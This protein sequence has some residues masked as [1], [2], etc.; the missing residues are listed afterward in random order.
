MQDFAEAK[1]IC[2][3]N[4]HTKSLI[5]PI[6]LTNERVTFSPGSPI[7]VNANLQIMSNP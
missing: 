6:W 2:G 5:V 3:V 7:P 1:L 4:L